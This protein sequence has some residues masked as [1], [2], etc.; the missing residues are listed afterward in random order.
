MSVNPSVRMK[1]LGSHR[2]DFHETWHLSIFRTSGMKIQVSFESDKH[3][4]TLYADQYTFLIISS[5][6]LLGMRNV[7]DKNY[8]ENQNTHLL[9]NNFFRKSYRT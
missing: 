1:Q 5:A 6:I 8:T 7:S 4:G 2:M 9:F 3:K